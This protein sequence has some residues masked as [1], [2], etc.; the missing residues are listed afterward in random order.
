MTEEYRMSIFIFVGLKC[1][2]NFQYIRIS[3]FLLKHML[4]VLQNIEKRYLEAKGTTSDFSFKQKKYMKT[5]KKSFF[6]LWEQNNGE[7]KLTE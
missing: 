2:L 1:Y 4:L 6:G 7:N 5:N 3:N